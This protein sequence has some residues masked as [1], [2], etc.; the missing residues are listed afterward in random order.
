MIA[1]WFSERLS[2]VS[3]GVGPLVESDKKKRIV[4][5]LN[6]LPPL[7]FS[8]VR[9]KLPRESCHED[10]SVADLGNPRHLQPG[11]AFHCEHR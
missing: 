1:A 8:S 10:V 11:S 2:Q 3:T 6:H 4:L 5:C 7:S 9:K